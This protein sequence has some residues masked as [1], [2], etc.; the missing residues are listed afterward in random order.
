MAC[1]T[2]SAGSAAST[3]SWTGP[4]AASP[5]PTARSR[6]SGASCPTRPRSSLS[7]DGRRRDTGQMSC[8]LVLLPG[9]DGTGELFAPLIAALDQ[10]LTPLVVR[11]PDEALD[12]ARHA[13]VA[14]ER[15]PSTGA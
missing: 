8:T 4:M 3:R 10:S 13:A 14:R 5:S 7:R 2:A 11:Y 6:K 12:Y 9:M 15:L 1:A